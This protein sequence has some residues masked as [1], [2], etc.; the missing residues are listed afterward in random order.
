MR[1]QATVVEKVANEGQVIVIL[2]WIFPDKRKRNLENYLNWRHK[3]LFVERFW[4]TFV[5]QWK[6]I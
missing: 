6:I 5:N 4:L 2:L 3:F 1:F